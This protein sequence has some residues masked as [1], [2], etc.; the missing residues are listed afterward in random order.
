MTVDTVFALRVTSAGESCHRSSDIPLVR[1]C[2]NPCRWRIHGWSAFETGRSACGEAQVRL[3][4]VM[5]TL[6]CT[7][8]RHFCVESLIHHRLAR[9]GLLAEHNYAR[10]IAFGNQDISHPGVASED[11]Y[12]ASLRDLS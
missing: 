5:Q 9:R 3:S 8:L 7:C 11:E 12:L 6:G 4:P 1:S 2:D 10:T